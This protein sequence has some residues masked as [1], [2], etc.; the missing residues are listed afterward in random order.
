MTTTKTYGALLREYRLAAGRTLEWVAERLAITPAYVSD[1]EHDR[2]APWGPQ[3]TMD[4]AVALDQDWNALLDARSRYYRQ[5]ALPLGVSARRD[6][7]ALALARRWSSLS[8]V[9]VDAI[10]VLLE[11]QP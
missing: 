9:Q 6:C 8:D 11:S 10:S 1:I 4:V 2:R 3:R 7:V 5:S